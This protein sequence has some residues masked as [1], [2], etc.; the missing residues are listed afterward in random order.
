MSTLNVNKDGQ[1]TSIKLS[2]SSTKI[3]TKTL[4]PIL[5]VS[6]KQGPPGIS[7]IN[8]LE[9]LRLFFGDFSSQMYLSE[10]SGLHVM[11]TFPYSEFGA[12]KYIIFATAFGKKQICEIL[13]LHNNSVVSSVEYAMIMTEEPLGSFSFDITGDNVRLLVDCPSANI[14]Y[15]V[16]RTLIEN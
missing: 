13:L 3:L 10:D 11:D 12:A 14:T 8:E 16:I 2:T 9:N 1:S 7:T 6:G 15:K 4:T 5:L